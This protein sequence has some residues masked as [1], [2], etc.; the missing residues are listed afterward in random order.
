MGGKA[1]RDGKNWLLKKLDGRR[2][3]VEPGRRYPDQDDPSVASGRTMDADRRQHDRRQEDREQKDRQDAPKEDRRHAEPEDRQDAGEHGRNGPGRTARRAKASSAS[4]KPDRRIRKA[5]AELSLD[6]SSLEGAKRSAMPATIAPELPLLV[7]H[8]PEGDGW[9][10]ELKLDGY[11]MIGFIRNGKARSHHPARQ[12]LDASIS[13][14]RRRR[15]G[16]LEIGDAILDGEVVAIARDGSCDFQALQNM[17][18]HGDDTQ[19]VFSVFDLLYH[20]GHDLRQVDLVVQKT[21]VVPVDRTFAPAPRHHPVQRSYFRGRRRDLRERLPPCDRG[22][23]LQAGRQPLPG[24]TVGRLGENQVLKR[25]EFVI[26][27]WTEPRRRA[28]GSRSPAAGLLPRRVRARLLRPRRDR[29]HAR[30]PARS[31]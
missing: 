22:N 3:T 27:G 10:H 29:I 9:L 26:G 21:V 19:I 20:G 13:E 2:G 15:A 31:A 7:R 24:A 16:K 5:G 18:R 25:Q 12:R 8:V 4:R 17:M 6:A 1:G 30:V 23:R 11:R 14:D 28:P